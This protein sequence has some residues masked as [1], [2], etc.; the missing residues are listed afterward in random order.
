MPQDF[1]LFIAEQHSMAL[2]G[3]VSFIHLLV[4][5]HLGCF[6]VWAIM[7]SAP[8]NIRVPKNNFKLK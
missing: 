7:N 2:I 1:S 3:H 5:R 8:K 4:D 6:R